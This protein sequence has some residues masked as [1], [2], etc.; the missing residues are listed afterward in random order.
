VVLAFVTVKVLPAAF[1]EPAPDKLAIDAP[2]VVDRISKVPA[3]AI[4]EDAATAPL[5]LNFKVAPLL[6]VVMPV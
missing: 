5:P 3:T 1:T 4:S 2:A 6:M